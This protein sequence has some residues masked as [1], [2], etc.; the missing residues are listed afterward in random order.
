MPT[1]STSHDSDRST[2]AP[3]LLIASMLLAA[4]L[5]LNAQYPNLIHNI[6]YKLLGTSVISTTGTGSSAES[7]RLAKIESLII[8]NRNKIDLREGRPFWGAA[9]HMV[10]LSFQG[11]ADDVILKREGARAYEFHRYGFGGNRE[12]VVMEFANNV[13]SC[14]HYPQRKQTNCSP[15]AR[16]YYDGQPFP[17][18]YKVS[19]TN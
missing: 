8:S 12:P 17:F 10:E 18:T 2:I 16:S 3:L 11:S 4:A 13:L 19:V 14:V 7:I 9:A 6:Q 5:Y 1:R 15:G